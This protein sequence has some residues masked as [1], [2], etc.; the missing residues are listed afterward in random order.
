MHEIH[1]LD[2]LILRFSYHKYE[3]MGGLV[4]PTIS[5]DKFL[6]LRSDADHLYVLFFSWRDSSLSYV[7][8]A[9]EVLWEA[10]FKRTTYTKNPQ[11]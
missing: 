8:P 7:F 5:T 6:Q 2:R 10:V 4:S 11:A 9:W 1:S 3:A